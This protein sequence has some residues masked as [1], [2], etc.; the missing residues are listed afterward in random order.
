MP[1]LKVFVDNTALPKGLPLAARA[2]LRDVLVD[3]LGVPE[4]AC[5]I[6]VIAV[7]GLPDQPAA[8]IEIS[9]MPHPER[10]ADALSDLGKALQSVVLSHVDAHSAFRCTLLDSSKYASI[11]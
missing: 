4:A 2:E 10:T 3:Q 8:N 7:Q 11:K 5:Q 9:L 6:A 1:N